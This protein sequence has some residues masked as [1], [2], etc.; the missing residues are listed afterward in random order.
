MHDANITDG[1]HAVLWR[2]S[3]VKELA[4]LVL[5][6][7]K[8]ESIVIGDNGEVE[9]VVVEVRGDS[10]RLGII[11]DR[12]VPIHRREIYDARKRGHTDGH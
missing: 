3:T 1:L 8:N 10:V 9:V 4:I 6:R 11:A 12:A 5:S 2:F 7:G